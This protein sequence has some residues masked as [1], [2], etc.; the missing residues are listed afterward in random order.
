M[1]ID[2]RITTSLL[3]GNVSDGVDDGPLKWGDWGLLPDAQGRCRHMGDLGLVS[4]AAGLLASGREAGDE[5]PR[6][7]GR[8]PA[9]NQRRL[10][11]YGGLPDVLRRCGIPLSSECRPGRSRRRGGAW[12]CRMTRVWPSARPSTWARA[13]EEPA[14]VAVPQFA[15]F[16]TVD[17]AC[18]C[19]V[20][21]F[22]SPRGP[23][24]VGC[25]SGCRMRVRRW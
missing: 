4:P 16:V 23:G 1:V 8:L 21:R 7:G 10:D 24:R 13:A 19:A 3:A 18:S 12:W 22:R 5:V 15:D 9:V 6:V 2:D 11:R 14:E 25:G 17:L 20:R